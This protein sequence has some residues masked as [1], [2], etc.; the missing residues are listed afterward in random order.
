[1][2]YHRVFGATDT[3]PTP[4]DIEACLAAGGVFSVDA[5]GWFRAEIA[6]V[7]VERWLAGEDGIRAELNAWAAAL[8]PL[9][10]HALMERIIQTR[11]LFVVHADG[12]ADARPLCR[13]LARLTEGVYQADD[14]GFFAADGRALVAGL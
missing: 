8:E 2:K 14:E 7:I 5:D 1:M 13:L 11:Q 9:E 3:L 6:G 10:E 4:E 12:A